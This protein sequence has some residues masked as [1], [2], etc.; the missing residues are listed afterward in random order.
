M[1]IIGCSKRAVSLYKKGEKFDAKQ[2]N[3]FGRDRGLSVVRRGKSGSG[4]LD[5]AA[6]PLP[7]K[8]GHCQRAHHYAAGKSSSADNSGPARRM[9]LARGRGPPSATEPHGCHRERTILQMATGDERKPI[10]PGGG[11]QAAA[12]EQS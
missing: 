4:R 3:S 6:V 9:I 10:E 5:H 12:K 1:V 8:H 7:G 2:Q 11:T